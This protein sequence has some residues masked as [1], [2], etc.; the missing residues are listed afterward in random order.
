MH[1]FFVYL[2]IKKILKQVI[3]N[4]ME[5]FLLLLMNQRGVSGIRNIQMRNGIGIQ[6]PNKAIIDQSKN[7]PATN[8]KRIPAQQK[9]CKNQQT[10]SN[11]L[12]ILLDVKQCCCNIRGTYQSYQTLLVLIPVFLELLVGLFHPGILAEKVKQCQHR[13]LRLIFPQ[14]PLEHS[15]QMQ[16]I[17]M[18]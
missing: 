8:D 14:G 16:L 15:Q 10:L 5:Q 7:V 17:G 12:Y 18:L 1:Y 9:Q 6:A 2:T 13:I 11:I 3:I 4:T